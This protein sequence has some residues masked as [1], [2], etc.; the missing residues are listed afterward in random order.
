MFQRTGQNVGDDFHVAMAVPAET[1]T[2]GDAVLVDDAQGAPAHFCRIVIIGKGKA[3]FGTQP[4]VIGVT[5]LGGRA[6]LNH[7]GL[8]VRYS[9]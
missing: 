1:R 2:R 4:A 7:C 6:K 5:A 8:R 3:V 9:L